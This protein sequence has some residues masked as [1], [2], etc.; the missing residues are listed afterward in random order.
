MLERIDDLLAEFKGHLSEALRD[1]GKTGLSPMSLSV[2]E[3]GLFERLGNLGR[4]I[5][6]E[7]LESSDVDRP[8][9][10]VDG[11]RH[12]RK[13]RGPEQYQCFLGRI[14]VE[15]TVYQANGTGSRTLC[16]LERN[17]GIQHCN[18]TP[19]AAEF[20]SYSAALSVPREIEE[21]CSRWHFL[22]PCATVIKHVASDVGEL[23]EELSSLYFKEAEGS[24]TEVEEA[25]VAV[26]SRDGTMVNVRG[27]GWRQSE[28]G[29]ISLYDCDGE[30]LSTKYVA[31]MP[32]GSAE[33]LDDKLDREIRAMKNRL[34][35]GA[36]LVFLADGALANWTYQSEHPILKRATG[37]LDF[38]HAAEKLREASEALFG[39]S[40]KKAQAWFL[41]QRNKLLEQEHGAE[42]VLQSLRN[43]RT[44]L[45]IRSGKRAQTLREVERY[46]YQNR[47]H[48]RY[49]RYISNGF[50][51]GSGVVE[52]ACKTVVGHRL[53]RSGM[54]W[55][56]RGGQ[57][58]LN[59]R[60]AVLSRRWDSLW[61]THEEVV[62]HAMRIP[63]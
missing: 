31:E 55:S 35:R 36:K 17:A 54:R 20:V 53:K 57:Q 45:G 2:F 52:A 12:Y 47:H 21:F 23:G 62:L 27:D 5:E 39:V 42:R 37:I 43:R 46:F 40:D 29:A 34:P 16:P 59:L 28:V 58:I 26:V 1:F 19:M 41:V 10:D 61:R 24:E 13:Y 63:A 14:D 4:A 38:F 60:C 25:K 9:L 56:P 44:R 50:P 33:G 48:M 49:H 6:R 11:E 51:I 3:R 7:L 8:Y 30:R 32:E 18:L 15:R 22:R